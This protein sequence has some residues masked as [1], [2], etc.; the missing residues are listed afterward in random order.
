MITRHAG[1]LQD[2]A[3][4][5]NILAGCPDTIKPAK[6]SRRIVPRGFD[7]RHASRGAA[8]ERVANQERL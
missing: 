8:D 4:G 5:E 2:N 1:E 3:F 7:A 6:T